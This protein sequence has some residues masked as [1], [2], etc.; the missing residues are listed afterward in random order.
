MLKLYDKQ[1]DDGLQTHAFVLL[2]RQ[3]KGQTILCRQYHIVI[4]NSN[5]SSYT[6]NT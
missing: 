1:S 5:H 3:H 4:E 6:E 2:P